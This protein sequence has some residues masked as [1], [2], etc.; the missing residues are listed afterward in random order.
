M[1]ISKWY[2]SALLKDN[3]TLFAHNH[4]FSSLGYPIVSFKF[5]PW[6]PC[7]HGNEFW[8]K[9]VYNSAPYKIIAG[10]L[11]LPPI[12]FPGLSDGVI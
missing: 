2:N 9:I 7:C 8:D 5:F 3:Y 4:L 10:C 12:F 11:H 6:D 1:K